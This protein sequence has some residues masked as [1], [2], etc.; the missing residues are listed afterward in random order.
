MSWK[1]TLERVHAEIPTRAG[2]RPFDATTVPTASQVTE[3]IGDIAGEIVGTVGDFDA[4]HVIN[5]DDTADDHVTLGDLA[6]RAAAI[7][8]ASKVEDQFY[9]EQQTGDYVGLDSTPSQHLYARYQRALELLKT[10]VTLW[11]RRRDGRKPARTV[12]T[13]A[14]LAPGRLRSGL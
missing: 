14:A 1:P 12:R 6:R 13:P 8:A 5:P 7:G 9:P 11:R 2:E 10:N 4:T 3:I